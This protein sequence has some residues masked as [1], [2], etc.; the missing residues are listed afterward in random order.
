MSLPEKPREPKTGYAFGKN[1]GH[2]VKPLPKRRFANI[3]QYKPHKTSESVKLARSVAAE[4]CGLAPYEK[5]ALE[6]L[7]KGNDKRCKKFLKKRIGNMKR[8]RA[9]LS[10][11]QSK[12][13]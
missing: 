1:K 11:L 13:I 10:Q 3:H 5:K 9:K 6:I 4:I 2:T 8:T 12:A 7:K